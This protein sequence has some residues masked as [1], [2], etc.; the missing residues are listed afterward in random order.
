MASDVLLP[1]LGLSMTEGAVTAW[2]K[3]LGSRVEKG[4]TLFIVETDK[5]EMEVEAT[6]SGYLTEILVEIG[7]IV[8][9]GTVIARLGDQP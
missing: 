3:D 7:Q 5:A 2:Q 6:S 1:Q 9:V 8:P 4:E